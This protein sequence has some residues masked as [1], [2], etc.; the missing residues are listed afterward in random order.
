MYSI[1][2]STFRKSHALSLQ[3]F[4]DLLA[5]AERVF[6]QDRHGVKVAQLKDGSI[7]KVFRVKRW[8][9]GAGIY[10][11]ARRFCRNVDRLKQRNIPVPEV[12]N[13]YH[14]TSTRLSVVRYSPLPGQTIKDIMKAGLLDEALAYKVGEFIAKVHALGIYFRGLHI[15]NIVRT[16]NG[17]LGLIDVSE[18]SIYWHLSRYRRLRNFARFWRVQEDVHAFGDGNINALINAYLRISDSPKITLTMIRKRLD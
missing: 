13:L 11:Y 17:E 14:V 1:F 6:E 4:H 16:P 15:G 3:A 2:K 12:L 7:V 9:S 18:L 8:W 10:S 5:G